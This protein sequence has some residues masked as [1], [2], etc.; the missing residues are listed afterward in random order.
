MPPGSG[1]DQVTGK[2]PGIGDFTTGET[3]SLGNLR[4]SNAINALGVTGYP[5]T[6]ARRLPAK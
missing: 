2:D 4:K 5:G 3:R 6:M 1:T